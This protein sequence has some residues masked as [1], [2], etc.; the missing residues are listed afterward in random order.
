MASTRDAGTQPAFVP[1]PGGDFIGHPRAL[2][3]LFGAE[4]WER[5]AYYGM[6]A[7]LA[8]YVATTFFGLLPEGEARA[9]ASLTYGAYTALIYATGLF[10]GFVADRYLGY[11]S[12]IVLGGV[13]MAAG[14][15]LLLIPDL[16][17][18]LMG[19]AVIVVGNG[20]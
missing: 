8:V 10:G 7:L 6:R 5:F 3:M 17:W 19:L 14:L 12:S 20:L 16:T 1:P 4:F 9:Q 13:L 18:F 2:W 11:R 15:F